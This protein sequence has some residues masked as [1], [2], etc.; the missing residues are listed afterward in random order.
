MLPD[1]ERPAEAV[2]FKPSSDSS[3]SVASQVM[4]P[5]D[6][7]T[8]MSRDKR[9]WSIGTNP[10]GL[11]NLMKSTATATND[12]RTSA[13]D[14]SLHI[15]DEQTQSMARVGDKNHTTRS[16]NLQMT[17]RELDLQQPSV[18]NDVPLPTSTSPTVRT[19]HWIKQQK[20]K[21]H[22]PSSPNIFP[23]RDPN[24]TSEYADTVPALN[25]YMDSLASTFD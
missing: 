4:S 19:A 23:N 12:S 18:N 14:D 2:G 6:M 10:L 5:D 15:L 3:G 11:L 25:R 16:T 24:I 8:T 20:R 17:P 9:A 1:D 7:L 13:T 21:K 22:R